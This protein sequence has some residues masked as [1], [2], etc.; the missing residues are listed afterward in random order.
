[1][2][3][4]P[5]GRRGF[6]L[7]EMLVAMAVLGILAVLLAEIANRACAAWMRGEAQ[8]SRSQAVRAVMNFLGTDLR[9]A[10][11]PLNPADQ[12][13]FQFVENPPGLSQDFRNRDSLFWQSAV[14]NSDA[15]EVAI[16][17]Y[18]VRW[19]TEDGRP[20]PRLCRLMIEAGEAGQPNPD[21]RLHTNPDA[22]LT[23]DLVETA[24]PGTEAAK[25]SGLLAE[26]VVGLWIRCFD[27]Q[28]TL[29]PNFD[30]R[31]QNQMPTRVEVGL[32]LLDTRAARRLDETRAEELRAA[33]RN[34]ET[35][36]DF[37]AAVAGSTAL[38][39]LQPHLVPYESSFHLNAAP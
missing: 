13:S 9:C 3:R 33:V 37:L 16:V 23:T 2:N 17:G 7:V 15:G 10:L 31:V 20:A 4:V 12:E 25:F 38:R 21:F 34:A 26:H 11:R 1:M 18:F 39:S 8:A 5:S 27:A 32:V 19:Y 24:A 6:T 22:W 14:G 30:S 29:I 35:A 28:G 36:G